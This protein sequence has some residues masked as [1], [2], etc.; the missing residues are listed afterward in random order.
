MSGFALHTTWSDEDQGK[1]G[2][3]VSRPRDGERTKEYRIRVVIP[4]SKPLTWIT[5]A[6]SVRHALKYAKARWPLAHAEI[7]K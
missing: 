4:G 2:P 6:P 1:Y 7:I 3:G 5:R